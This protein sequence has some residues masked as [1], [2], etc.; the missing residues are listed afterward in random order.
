MGK[1][2]GFVLKHRVTTLLRRSFRRII[3]P[4]KYQK[5]SPLPSLSA[6]PLSKFLNWTKCLKTKAKA[7][8][9]KAQCSGSGSGSGS[10]RGYIQIGQE[11]VEEKSMAV[12][13]GHMAVY[14]GQKDGDFKRVLVPVIYFNHPL[15]SGLL[16][17]VEDEYGFNHP[18]G[19]T[20]PCRIS[21]FERVQTRIKQGRVA[22]KC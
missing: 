16:R 3:S 11:P 6:K 5:N 10:G 9:S 1:I 20:I 19:I 22:P 14:V 15:F 4:A 2:Q 12:P 8:C 18:G 13:K 17:E 21:E 7:I